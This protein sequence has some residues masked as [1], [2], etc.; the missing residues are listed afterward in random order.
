MGLKMDYRN[1]MAH[2]LHL[3]VFCEGF[4][5]CIRNKIWCRGDAEWV[6]GRMVLV[7]VPIM[8]GHT[9]DF[10]L[11]EGQSMVRPC[12]M[13][14]LT[15]VLCVNIERGMDGWPSSVYFK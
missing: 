15:S 1:A 12:L 8:I 4:A 7:L 6:D 13:K 11:F 9:T 14:A 10:L 3:G 5:Q 2:S